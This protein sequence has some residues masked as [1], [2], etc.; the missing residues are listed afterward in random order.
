MFYTSSAE[1][2]VSLCLLQHSAMTMYGY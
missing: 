2:M 1:L